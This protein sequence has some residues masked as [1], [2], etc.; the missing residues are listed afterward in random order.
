MRV[1][2]SFRSSSC[3]TVLR[4][5]SMSSRTMRWARWR[6]SSDSMA[7]GRAFDKCRAYFFGS[8]FLAAIIL[9]ISFIVFRMG[10][11][12]KYVHNL[13]CEVDLR[14]QAVMIAMNVEYGAVTHLI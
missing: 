9:P 7:A 3:S 2:S 5:L 8:I 11:H 10:Q 13:A 12:G 14:D 1:A 4:L 6:S